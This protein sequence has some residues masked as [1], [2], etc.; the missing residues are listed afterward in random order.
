MEVPRRA[1]RLWSIL[2]RVVRTTW[3][4][5]FHHEVIDLVDR[6]CGGVLD[7]EHTELAEALL[8]G[9]KDSVERIEVADGGVLEDAFRGDLRIGALDTL[10]GDVGLLREEVR[11]ADHRLADGCDLGVGSAGD[12][13]LASAR[14]LHEE[15]HE[16][17]RIGLE[18]VGDLGGGV[19]HLGALSG[20]VI[21]AHAVWPSCS[22]PILS[23]TSARS[24]KSSKI[25]SSMSS[26]WS[27]SSVMS[28]MFAPYGR[29]W[30]GVWSW[31]RGLRAR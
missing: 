30:S 3:K 19:S 13:V 22:W 10:A 2:R 20:A 26:I 11:R 5:W 16:H 31:L 17:L 1:S 27:L 21:H 14:G 28:S 24:L 25:L 15:F 23:A 9:T 12:G 7:G 6:A 8:D 18:I 4:S 29:L